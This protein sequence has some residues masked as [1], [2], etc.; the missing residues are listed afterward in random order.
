M[1][2][3]G[4]SRAASLYRTAR[5]LCLRA[6]TIDPD[7]A[8]ITLA[9]LRYTVGQ[10]RKEMMGSLGAASLVC[11]SDALSIYRKRTQ[12]KCKELA[13]RRVFELQGGL[14]DATV[15][16]YVLINSPTRTRGVG[17]ELSIEGRKP[18]RLMLHTGASGIL[19]TGQAVEKA[20]L[21]HVGTTESWGIGDGG[22]RKG[23]LAIADT[24][25]IGSLDLKTCIFRAVEAKEDLAGRRWFGRHRFF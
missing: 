11:S 14:K 24:C 12:P 23:S 19:L 17:V 25:R 3:I 1:D 2:S 13:T 8:L 4:S 22:V 18:L 15:P 21:K 7:D 6:H 5:L 9:F 20:G 16:L 10:T